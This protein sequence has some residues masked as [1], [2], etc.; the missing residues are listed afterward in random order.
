MAFPATKR[1]QG[2]LSC[3][4]GKM[5]QRDSDSIVGRGTYNYGVNWI[6]IELS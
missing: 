1:K 4:I 6:V 5:L 2:E 3:D